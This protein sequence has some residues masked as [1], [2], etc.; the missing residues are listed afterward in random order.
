MD[1][2]LTE[3]SHVAGDAWD[4]Q[5]TDDIIERLEARPYLIAQ[6]NNVLDLIQFCRQQRVSAESLKLAAQMLE[7]DKLAE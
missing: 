7:N 3:A 6:V 5:L 1:D 4:A 2:I